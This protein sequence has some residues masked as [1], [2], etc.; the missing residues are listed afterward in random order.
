MY[1][2]DV[3][4]ASEFNANNLSVVNFESISQQQV[5]IKGEIE[6]KMKYIYKRKDNRY[7]GKRTLNGKTYMVYGKTQLQCLEKLKK[8]IREKRY[9]ASKVE[10]INKT[11]YPKS[12]FE[13][14]I[15]WFENFKKNNIVPMSQKNY[16]NCIRHDIRK[17]E[18]DVQ[19]LNIDILQKFAN[20]LTKTRKKEYCLMIVKQVV[21]FAKTKS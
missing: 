2:S 9:I 16:I 17:L 3:N 8:A 11:P 20:S 15:Y 13:F 5:L 12:F 21:K 14:T 1:E 18:C 4:S 7:V 10:K 19:D 6:E